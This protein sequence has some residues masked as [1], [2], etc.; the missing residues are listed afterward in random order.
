MEEHALPTMQ[1]AGPVMVARAGQM[2]FLM[3]DAVMA[4]QFA[5]SELAFLSLGMMA[6]FVLMVFAMGILQGTMILISQAYGAGEY[7]NCGRTWRIGMIHAVVFGV[8]LGLLAYLVSF[9]FVYSGLEPELNEGAARVTRQASWAMPAM[10]GYMCSIFFLEALG[11][12]RVGMV[13]VVI[14][15]IINVGL[16]YPLIYGWAG[17]VEPLGAEGAIIATSAI[18]WLL[19]IIAFSFILMMP[20]REGGDHY[21]TRTSLRRLMVDLRRLGG[22]RGRRIRRL[23]Y[24][25]A[26]AQGLQTLAMALLSY[27]AGFLGTEPLAAYNVAGNVGMLVFMVALGLQAATTVRVGRAVGAEDS[28]SIAQAGWT[29]AFIGASIMFPA[30]AFMLAKPALMARIFISEPEVIAIAIGTIRVGAATVMINAL[31]NIITG[32]VRGAGDV[33]V[34]M[35]LHIFSYWAVAVP[36]AWYLAFYL[37]IG[38]TGL[39]W[40]SFMGS[41]VAMGML[42]TRFHIISQRTISRA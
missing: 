31:M 11:R 4:G 5:A 15:N 13:A 37:N 2:F 36:A 28:S 23:G 41:V 27:M 21:G 32:A 18:R 25:M 7:R 39:M 19:F 9:L 34:P 22:R 20:G 26:G 6:Q 1:L 10:M 24:P 33:H 3:T 14:G 30:V 8:G 12:P 17:Y 35:W 16:N 40:G 38:V 29:G 42:S